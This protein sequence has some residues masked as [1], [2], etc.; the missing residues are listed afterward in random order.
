[1]TE[2]PVISRECKNC[3]YRRVR[4]IDYSARL[5]CQ[6]CANW[7]GEEEESPT[8]EDL[9]RKIFGTGGRRNE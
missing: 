7:N 3:D 8:T 9:I 1:M 6:L 2:C 4:S 5:V